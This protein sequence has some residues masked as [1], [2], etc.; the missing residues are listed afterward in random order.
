MSTSAH[1]LIGNIAYWASRLVPTNTTVRNRFEEYD[2]LRGQAADGTGGLRK[3]YVEWRASEEDVGA[4]D[5]DNRE[6]WHNVWLH[7]EYPTAL[8]FTDLQ[9]LVLQDRHDLI[10]Q[11]RDATT[12]VG[13]DAS[14]A[15]TDIGLIRRIV[16]GVELNR[17]EPGKWRLTLALRNFMRE[18]E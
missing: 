4:S 7:V 12:R 1:R 8:T 14:H 2:P 11:L 15:A 9:I 5:A 3:F 10:K 13:Y 16:A 17:Q 18:A 6:A